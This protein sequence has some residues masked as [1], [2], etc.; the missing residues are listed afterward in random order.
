MP[1]YVSFLILKLLA[2]PGATGYPPELSAVEVWCIAT[3]TEMSERSQIVD[4]VQ[5]GYSPQ[6]LDYGERPSI[7]VYEW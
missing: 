4:L 2:G 3:S 1:R 7:K 6:F 5:R